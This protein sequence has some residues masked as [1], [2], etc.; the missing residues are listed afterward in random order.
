VVPLVG[1]SRPV[2]GVT[3]SPD[4]KRLVSAS[5]DGTLKVWEL[6]SGQELLTLPAGGKA[7]QCGFSPDGRQLFA[8][9]G[10]VR[11]WDPTPPP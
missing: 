9:A 8:V 10:V 2:L 7:S 4:G 5:E 1:H 3:F 11:I 6:T